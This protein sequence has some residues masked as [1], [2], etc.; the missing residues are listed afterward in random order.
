MKRLVLTLACAA[1]LTG[2]GCC[3]FGYPYWGGGGYGAGYAPTYGGGYG[4]CPGG[5]CGGYP[6]AYAPMGS[7]ASVPYYGATA[8]YPGYTTAGLNYLPVQ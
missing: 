3:G 1:M 5:A 8:S 6:G 2:S 7:T 4:G